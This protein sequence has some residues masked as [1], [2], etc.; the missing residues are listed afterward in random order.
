[1]TVPSLKH[2]PEQKYKVTPLELFFDLVCLPNGAQDFLLTM[3]IFLGYRVPEDQTKKI[4]K[5]G[6]ELKL[7]E[8]SLQGMRSLSMVN[9]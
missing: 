5:S 8:P 4:Q 6:S 2:T 9:D 7:P 3:T 1:M